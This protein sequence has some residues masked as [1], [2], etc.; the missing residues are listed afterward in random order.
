MSGIWTIAK[1]EIKSLFV[2]P[3]G[4]IFVALFALFSG[5]WFIR[6]LISFDMAL[7]QAKVQAQLY[8]NPEM[9]SSLTINGKL[10]MGI[11]DFA[12]F[13]FIF[14]VPAITMRSLCEERNQGTYELLMTSPVNSWEIILG[15]FLAGFLFLLGII[16]THSLY[17]LVM[18]VFGNPEPGPVLSGYL[19]LVLGGSALLAVGIFIS[20][21]TKSYLLSYFGAMIVNLI[22]M[23]FG[24]IAPMVPGNLSDFFK[25]IST[26]FNF[27]NFNMGLITVSST[28][29][30]V[31]VA[32]FFLSAAKISVQSITRT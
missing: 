23:T 1:R 3:P 2:T 25:Y 28:V 32:I 16:A 5:F 31:T 7:Q 29:Y 24:W 22:L 30:F 9:L 27:G 10:I 4:Y 13:L 15:K 11:I 12:F 20:S 19:G 21:L 18:F 26:G 14:V 6:T 17:L 8:Q